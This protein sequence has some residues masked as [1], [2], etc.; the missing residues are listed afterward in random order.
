MPPRACIIY[1]LL[2]LKFSLID[3]TISLATRQLR[4]SAWSAALRNVRDAS[5]SRPLICAGDNNS[6]ASSSKRT[7]S[8]T[9]SAAS[10][11]TRGLVA[12]SFKRSPLRLSRDFFFAIV[13]LQLPGQKAS[14]SHTFDKFTPPEAGRPS[15]LWARPLLK[16]PQFAMVTQR[17]EDTELA[18]PPTASGRTVRKL[19]VWSKICRVVT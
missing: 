18:V 8:L 6:D 16:V 11:T 10:A 9:C 15:C 12:S 1:D 3:S 4:L 17:Q 5:R 13:A 14:T 2:L 19:P 7:D